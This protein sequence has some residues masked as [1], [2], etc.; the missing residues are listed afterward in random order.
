[1]L[2]SALPENPLWRPARRCPPR[3]AERYGLDPAATPANQAWALLY[4]REPELYDRL[5][6]GENL[7]PRI[8]AELPIEAVT[9][10]D[11]GAGSG[12]LTLPCAARAAEVLALEPAAG[13]R[14]ELA[15]KLQRC[16][17]ANVRIIAGSDQ[18]IPLSAGSV[19]VT[20]SCAA[21]GADPEL[22]GEQGLAELRRVTRP[23]GQIF[24][25][26]PDDPQWFLD[27]GFSYHAFAGAME[28]RFRDLQTAK[29]CA[30]IFY[31]EAALEWIRQSGRPILPYSVLGVNAPRDLCR[32]TVA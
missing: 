7:H 23:G 29:L 5:V 27:R 9:V 21:F 22:G 31:G 20:V 4:E 10:L 6:E 30:E 18:A 32:C 16:G 26:W 11:V 17:I 15:A 3:L 1:M 14:R 19:D 13:L 25:L 2:D 28:T 24:I 12:R 8:L